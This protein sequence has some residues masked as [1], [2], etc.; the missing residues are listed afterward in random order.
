MQFETFKYDLNKTPQQGRFVFSERKFPA[1]FGGFNNGKTFALCLRSWL[2]S[3]RYPGN[4][5][6]ICRR[7]VKEL[8]DTTRDEFF[9]MVGCNETTIKD[10]PLVDI[11]RQD[12]NF[13]RL[14]NGSEI[15][16]RHLSDENA[17]AAL[18]SM[19]IRWF[20]IDQAEEVPEAAFSYLISRIGRTDIDGVTGLTLP[21]AWGACSGNPKGHNWIWERWKQDADVQGMTGRYYH[22]EEARTDEGPLTSPEYIQIL[23]DTY[24][25][26]WFKRYVLGS[27]DVDSGRVY[28][29]FDPEIHVID[30][31][32]INPRWKAGIGVDLGYNHPTVFEWCA[33]DY[34]G[35]WYVY[36][37]HAGREMTPNQHAPILKLKGISRTDGTQ[38][39]I[40]GP[41][42]A[43][44]RNPITGINYQQAYSDEDIYMLRGNQ[45]DP[46]VGIMKIKQM[47]RIQEDVKNPFT[48]KMGAPRL[49]IF[50]NCPQLIKEMG[51]Y[52]WKELKLGEEKTKE[53]P[54]TVNKVNDDACDALRM[55]GL[56][57]SSRQIPERPRKKTLFEEQLD[58]FTGANVD[59]ELLEAA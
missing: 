35:N 53:E 46:V 31:F 47:L 5:G 54:D 4:R 8:E 48:G 24:P 57:F 12:K 9:R 38:L 44:N 58:K 6:V 30:P 39:P 40:Y 21:P 43:A 51:I 33:V 11:W 52:S 42:D 16:F 19:S 3:V 23:K 55:F 36:N 7:Q 28:D 41:H 1:Y 29:E 14:K 22:L 37:E 45:M 17:L 2:H 50:R 49:F 27:W 56:G 10:H 13:L 18:L 34:N 32:P 20:A 26:R 15:R 25:P 59:E